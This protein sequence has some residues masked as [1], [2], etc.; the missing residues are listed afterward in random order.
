MTQSGG[1]YASS[2][3][4]LPSH[5]SLGDPINQQS[6]KL[7]F[8]SHQTYW[9]IFGGMM[10]LG[11]FSGELRAAPV[12]N[13]HGEFPVLNCAGISELTCLLVVG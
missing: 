4:P 3:P 9:I 12:L 13:L 5:L 10:V 8:V 2:L 1:S 7:T 11:N 6:R